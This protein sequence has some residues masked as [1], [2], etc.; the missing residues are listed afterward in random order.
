MMD[1]VHA[2]CDDQPNQA[3][4]EPERQSKVGMMEDDRRQRC[5]LPHVQYP[6]PDSDQQDLRDTPGNGQ[7]KLAEVEAQRRRGV[8]IQIDVMHDVEAPEHV[9]SVEEHMPE[10]QRIVEQHQPEQHLQPAR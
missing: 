7:S 8:K 4:F 6:W 1:A 2:R 3:S 5:L 10:I 9:C